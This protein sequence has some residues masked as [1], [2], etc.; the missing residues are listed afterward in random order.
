MNKEK[1]IEE[2]AHLVCEM[3]LKPNSCQECI[4]RK[5]GCFT[6]PKM[7]VLQDAGYRKIYDDHQRQCTCYA[8]GCQMAESLKTDVAR[9]IFE[10]IDNI[11]DFLKLYNPCDDLLKAII[12]RIT[13]LKKKYTEEI[14]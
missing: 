6:L 14:K 9:E 4:G 12:Y 13:E 10:E 11:L 2:M 5:G 3:A 1:Q 8:L 7:K